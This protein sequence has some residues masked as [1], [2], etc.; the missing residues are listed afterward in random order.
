MRSSPRLLRITT[1]PIS[2]H[3]LLSG[4][5]TYFQ[6][7]GFHVLTASAE[8]NE[9]TEI[10]RELKHQVIPMTRTITPFQ[11]LYCLWL[12]VR[13]I[14][15]FK[16]DIVHTHTPKAGLL[17]MMAAWVCR[18]PVRMHTVAGLPLM[19]EQG[20]RRWL[21]IRTEWITYFCA[22]GVYPNSRGLMDYIQGGFSLVGSGQEAVRSRHNKKL[23]MIG[24][25]S[26][27]G[28]DVNFF[29]RTEL[30]EREAKG[31]RESNAVLENE[32]VFSFVGR[33]VRDKGLIELVTAFQKTS[34]PSRLLLVGGFEEH[35]DP[36]PEDIITFLK[37]DKRVILAGFQKDVRPWMMASDVFVFPSYREGF[38]NVVMQAACLE[39]PCIVSD[40]NGCNELVIHKETG[41]IVPAKNTEKLLQAMDEMIG[42]LTKARAMAKV[43]RSFVVANFDREYVW[44]ELLRE[45][46]ALIR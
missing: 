46:K 45:Y 30:L 16:P 39:L 6:Q 24:R 26:S 44:G 37:N 2:L 8:G 25:G 17:G 31:I 29:K 32:V 18:V 21:L 10:A 19:E 33:L 13:L 7:Q 35:L 27:N 36:L 22:S 12:L 20:W 5:L 40:I 15:R 11:D 38:P 41:L 14:R 23:K 28:I 43:A 4:Q 9:V 1:V 34:I 42:D 3:Y